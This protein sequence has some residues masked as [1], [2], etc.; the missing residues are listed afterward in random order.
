MMEHYIVET[1]QELARL[2]KASVY[3]TE[4]AIIGRVRSAALFTSNLFEI[5]RSLAQ[6]EILSKQQGHPIPKSCKKR[7][8]DP[9]AT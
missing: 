8:V 9:C 7:T 5:I 6:Q 3:A 2:V 1:S 4:D